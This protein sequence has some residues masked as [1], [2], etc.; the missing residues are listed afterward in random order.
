VEI[1]SLVQPSRGLFSAAVSKTDDTGTGRRKRQWIARGNFYFVWNPRYSQTAFT[2]YQG[3]FADGGL[4]GVDLVP[5]G[6][7]AKPGIVNGLYESPSVWNFRSCT[8][9]W[10]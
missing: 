9:P 2:L 7:L 10:R 3:N 5:G 6:S 4:A 8:T 1:R